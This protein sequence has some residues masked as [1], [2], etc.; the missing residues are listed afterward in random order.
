MRPEGSLLAARQHLD[1]CPGS[2]TSSAAQPS[3]PGPL[4]PALRAPR[5]RVETKVGDVDLTNPSAT[6]AMSWHRRPRRPHRRADGLFPSERRDLMFAGT[7]K[8]R[9]RATPRRRARACTPAPILRFR[10]RCRGRL[11]SAR[12]RASLPAETSACFALSPKRQP[13]VGRAEVRCGDADAARHQR[14]DEDDGEKE[15]DAANARAALISST[16][17]RRETRR[18]YALLSPRR[19]EPTRPPD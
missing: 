12:S 9:R 2:S 8:T 6:R 16:Y 17:P 19:F 3:R 4:G 1:A 15:R 7:F 14:H 10:K 13:G 5:R 18:E 11:P